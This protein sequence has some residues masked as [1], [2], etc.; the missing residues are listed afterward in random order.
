MSNVISIKGYQLEVKSGQPMIKD[1]DLAVKLGYETPYSIRK[2]IIRMI[3]KGQI[4]PEQVFSTVEKTPKGGR[5]SKVFH[6]DQHATIKVITKSETK[7][8]DEITDEVIDVFLAFQNK[9]S[10]PKTR[11][12]DQ[13]SV[14]ERRGVVI[15]RSTLSAGKLLGT[16]VPMSRA[17]AVSRVKAVTGID[18]TLLIA[19]NTVEEVPVTPTKIGAELGISGIKTNIK[20]EKAG[21]QRKI[22]GEWTPTDKGKKYGS[23][24]PYTSPN[25]DHTG[26]RALWYSSKVKPLIQEMAA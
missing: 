8:S 11:A 5:P 15:L 26:Y 12:V 20:L 23:Y 25:S 10:K 1:L 13:Q 17:I 4:K 24:E 3:E 9:G 2:L 19:N 21:L 22:G 18:Y 7:K 16:S 14:Q 6:L